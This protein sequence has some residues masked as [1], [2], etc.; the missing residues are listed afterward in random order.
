ML[1]FGKEVQFADPATN[2][3]WSVDPAAGEAVLVNVAPKVELKLLRQN[4][5]SAKVEFTVES[6]AATIGFTNAKGE[7]IWDR[8]G[9]QIREPKS[10]LVVLDYTSGRMRL[11]LNGDERPEFKG[12]CI[13]LGQDSELSMTFA[14]AGFANVKVH[15]VDAA[16]S[17]SQPAGRSLAAERAAAAPAEK[18]AS[19]E[20]I[21]DALSSSVIPYL[22]VKPASEAAQLRGLVRPI[23]EALTHPCPSCQGKGT[24]QVN[25][26]EGDATHA[27]T[28]VLTQQCATCKGKRTVHATADALNTVMASA[29]KVSA[30][31]KVDDSPQL[32]AA[33]DS[34]IDA[35]GNVWRDAFG[36][37]VLEAAGAKMINRGKVRTG[38]PLYGYGWVR[39]TYPIPA[40]GKA[41]LIDL[42]NSDGWI[43]VKEPNL[44]DAG[45][46][47]TVSF[48][49]LYA[50]TFTDKQG[51][52]VYVAQGGFI[53]RSQE[54]IRD[55][56]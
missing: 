36:R 48:G 43:L 27:R 15:V 29:C 17:T 33:K 32:E 39:G 24:V 51:H 46:F 9:G 54:Q 53:V 35:L 4:F 28:T 44:T 11:F 40:G 47:T 55:N 5:A 25:H 30:T 52:D 42:G 22:T 2:S 8:Q 34:V 49:G 6:D 16:G 14:R 1:A 41:Y 50:G 37:S 20:L 38:A 31:L 19:H 12:K 7:L 18:Q 26:T 56:R 45:S 23:S 13:L 21:I 3:G 10:S